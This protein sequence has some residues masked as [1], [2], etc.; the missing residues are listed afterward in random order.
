MF[1]LAKVKTF[2]QMTNGG[3]LL[4]KKKKIVVKCVIYMIT[5]RVGIALAMT[6]IIKMQSLK[7]K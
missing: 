4:K 6:Y 1:P 5:E 7:I 3:N 2:K